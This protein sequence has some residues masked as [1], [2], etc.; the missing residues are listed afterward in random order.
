MTKR[1]LHLWLCCAVI[2]LPSAA[3]ARLAPQRSVLANGLILLTSEQRS[4]PMITLNLLIEA[5]SRYDAKGREGLAHLTARLLTHGTRSRSS[6]EISE[7]LDFI[8]ASLSTGSD[9]DLASVSLTLLK[10]DLDAGLDLL[11]EILTASVFPEEEIDRQKQSVIASIRAKEEDPGEIAQEKFLE[12]LFPQHAYGRPVEGTEDSVRAIER[13]D[14]IGFYQRFYRP[15]GAI[16]AVVGDIS[17]QEAAE[18]LGKAFAAWEKKDPFREAFVAP[19]YGKPATLRVH[20]SL[21][22]ANVVLGHAGVPRGHPD[23][24]AIQVM[25]YILGGGGFSSRLMD[26]IRNQRGLAYSVYSSFDAEKYVGTFQVV[27]QTKNETAEEAIRIARE[28]VQRIR[29]RGVTE[30][31]LQAAKD[32]L[33]GSFPLRLDTNRRIASFLAYVEYLELGLDYPERYSQLVQRV[34]KEDVLRAAKRYLQP[35]KLIVVVVA[36]QE[37][38]Q[39]KQ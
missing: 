27:M 13:A 29:E 34:T 38:A 14:L 4:L 7:A 11:A 6:P 23:Y 39:A 15:N 8:G 21:T 3:P 17:H 31:E 18:K 24:Y 37:K 36:D 1:L 26:S 16:L 30:A 33:I 10:K 2:L 32:Y 5:G 28:E 9:T 22:Q 35:E 20:K 25:N 19:S 12:G